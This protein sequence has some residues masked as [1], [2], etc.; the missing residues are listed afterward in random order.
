[1]FLRERKNGSPEKTEGVV[2]DRE[3]SQRLSC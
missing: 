3:I 2:Q 1:M